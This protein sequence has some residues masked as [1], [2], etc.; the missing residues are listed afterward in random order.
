MRIF[1][2]GL[3][4]TSML[5]A[6]AWAQSKTLTLK[7]GKPTGGVVT[8]VVPVEVPRS[9]SPEIMQSGVVA[10]PAPVKHDAPAAADDVPQGPLNVSPDQERSCR[11]QANPSNGF[12]SLHEYT[13]AYIAMGE[14]SLPLADPAKLKQF[15]QD[16]NPSKWAGSSYLQ[17]QGVSQS[18]RIDRTFALIRQMRDALGNPEPFDYVFE[19]AKFDKQQAQ[20]VHPQLEGG[21]GAILELHNAWQIYQAIVPT[22][23]SNMTAAAAQAQIQAAMIIGPG[24][25]L[26]VSFPVQDSPA[27]GLLRTGDIVEAVDGQPLAG[28]TQNAAIDLIRGAVGKGV[29]LTI[30]RTNSQG[31]QVRVNLTLVRTVVA[32]H[33]LTYKDVNGIRHI[34]IANF[35]NTYLLMDF[36]N[37]IVDAK[38]KG[39]KG[40]V[41]DVRGNPGGRLDYVKAMLQMLVD[42]GEI[43]MTQQRDPGTNQVIQDEFV[44]DGPLALTEEKAVGAPES[45]KKV[46]FA[47]RVAFSAQYAA[48]A[49]KDPGYVDEHPLQTIVDANMPIIVLADDDSYSASEIFAGGLKETHRAALI[50]KPTAGKDDIMSEVGVP[51]CDTTS[52]DNKCHTG[53]LMVI[54][55]WFFP[56]GVNTDLTGVV[57]NALIEQA[58]DFGQTD[59]QFEA[60]VA[61]INAELQRQADAKAASDKSRKF[62]SDRFDQEIKDR[63]AN[64]KLPPDQQ[65]PHLQQ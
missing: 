36:Y 29:K 58:A 25:E 41:L 22:F 17:T 4:A 39:I 33:A 24:H 60:G 16:W 62:N 8:D 45:S 47:E 50:G 15:V 11:S 19:P 56:G 37:A 14:I 35:E 26:M 13:C 12:D 10:P 2:A 64:D 6:P 1:V 65:N 44:M 48:N 27:D 57:P 32:E 28:M 20:S 52:P 63:N 55:G 53:G 30:L 18:D 49:A 21:I 5:T 42:R 46:E 43:L 7:A 31:K 9:Q 54:S 59:A 51:E 40:L 61:A 34:T 3:L 23:P 38:Q